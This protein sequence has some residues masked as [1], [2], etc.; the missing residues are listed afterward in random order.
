MNLNSMKV[1]SY[2]DAEAY[3]RDARA[4]NL[5]WFRH[6]RYGLFLHYGLYSLL[7]RHEWV[8]LNE[9]ISVADI[10]KLAQDFTAQNFD[11]DR[12]A[13]FAVEAGF[14]YLN[15][16]TRHHD[17]FCLWN[18]RQTDFNSVQARNCRRDLLSELADAC[19]KHRLGLFFYYSH[20]RDWRHPHAPG[21]DR[22]GGR[23]RPEYE[24]PEPTYATGTA[25][26]LNRYLDF[27][28]AQIEELLTN[29]GPIA[30]IW[31]DGVGV[32]ISDKTKSPYP[33]PF[34]N[35]NT[36]PEFKLQQLYDLIHG[37]QPQTL[38]SYKQGVT[39]TEDFIA[40]EHQAIEKSGRPGEVCTT[41]IDRPKI[42]WGYLQEARGQHKTEV[43]VWQALAEARAR[44]FNL[45][46]NT[47]PLPDGSLD[48]EDVEVLLN[49]GE[50]LKRQGF[51]NETS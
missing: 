44:D 48:A 50:R 27:M 22:Y 42:S 36:A 1:P 37:L 38:V 16:T 23:A 29:Y 12:I 24:P 14:K 10:E 5:D 15:I 28:S 21:N 3:R 13:A 32:T 20:G 51:P 43:E 33:Q 18:T 40:P 2:L 6:A 41:M 34:N 4:A 8:Q 39:G 49:V 31:L 9:K 46:L 11:A 26:D 17:G 47:G 19:D 45:L 30:G 35:P 25:H 7:G